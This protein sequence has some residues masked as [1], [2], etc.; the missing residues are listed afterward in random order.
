MWGSSKSTRDPY[1]T[2]AGETKSRF[3][4]YVFIS[5]NSWFLGKL[6]TVKTTIMILP[7]R[8][9]QLIET[10]GK[11]LEGGVLDPLDRAAGGK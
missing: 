6:K 10:Q 8:L 9:L 5:S 4:E 11:A 7:S 1:I 2:S 3:I